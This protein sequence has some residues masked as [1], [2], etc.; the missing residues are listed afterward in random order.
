MKQKPIILCAG[1]NGRAVIYGY[2]DQDPVPGEAV[3]VHRAR[4]VLYWDSKCGGL[5]GLAAN[6]PKGDTR[7][8]AEVPRVV[9]TCW[10]EFCDVAERAAES[11][12]E[13]KP[14]N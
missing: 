1:Q 3:T 7:I 13:W 8:T 11:I 9:E 10:Q 12:D 14:V 4:M 2:V 6:G 5:L